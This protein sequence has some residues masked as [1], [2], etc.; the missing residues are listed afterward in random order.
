M[1]ADKCL[2]GLGSFSLQ[3]PQKCCQGIAYQQERRK[4]PR[5]VQDKGRNKENDKPDLNQ[6]ADE[7]VMTLREVFPWPWN[8]VL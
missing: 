6:E 7:S 2:I 5:P 4:R 8:G 1:M 3:V